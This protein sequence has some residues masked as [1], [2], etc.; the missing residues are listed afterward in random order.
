[1]DTIDTE[2]IRLLQNDGRASWADLAAAVRLTPPAV[3]DRVHRL[4]EAGV[5]R[6]FTARLDP[7][8]MGLP[9]LSFVAVT[10]GNPKHRKSFL[11]VVVGEPAILE[12]HHVAG[13]DDFFLKV[14][15]AGVAE[16]DRLLSATLKGIDGVVRS[17]TTIALG[18]VKDDSP[19]PMPHRKKEKKGGGRE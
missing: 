13:D 4:T 16:L 5:I 9:L 14:R 1:M 19:L 18:T 11:E 3:A 12:C 8:A 7:A 2:L 17:R 15:T 10:L 6:G